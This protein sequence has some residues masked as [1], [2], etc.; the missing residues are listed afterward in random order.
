M[1]SFPRHII[2]VILIVL[3]SCGNNNPGNGGKTDEP[4]Y[5]FTGTREIFGFYGQNRY[6]YCPSV[7]REDDGTVHMFFCGNPQQNVM[8]DNIY[9]VRINPDGSQT[10]AKSVL[11]PGESGSWDDHHICD[12]SV[13]AG[14]FKMD[15]QNY[16][17]AMFFLSN[18]YSVYY[19][20]I[21][22]A[23]A[24]APDADQWIKYPY[25]AVKKTWGTDGDQNRGNGNK[26]WGAGQPSAVSLDNK[27]K[28]LLTYTIG[29]IRGTRIVWSLA[30]LSDMSAYSPATAT[31]MVDSGLRNIDCT[32][33]DYTCNSDFAV[34]R[35][36][37]TIFMVRP[38]QPNASD[39]PSYL[40]ESLE[41]DSMTLSGFLASSGKWTP[42]IRITPAET[43]FPRNHNAG[44][45]RDSYGRIP[46]REEPAVYYTVSKA[47][48]GVNAS[49]GQHA[50]WTYHIWKGTAS[51]NK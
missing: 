38:V 15:G 16:R 2:P 49:T 26:S 17:Y 46:N 22:V 7:I 3:S 1:K 9:H 29:D 24:N 42:I 39:Y 6:S 13:I 48:P 21:G 12:P 51:V 34:S 10:A 4:A 50:E 41:I 19:N 25:Q 33:N 40:N 23:F 20:E 18:R 30:D 37:E 47:A 36:H 45:E 28:V 35:D 5:K 8:V 27:G 11:Q 31:A 44:I 14:E 43:N 32:G